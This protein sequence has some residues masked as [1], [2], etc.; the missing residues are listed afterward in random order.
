MQSKPAA[1]K[2]T[3]SNIVTFKADRDW[4]APATTTSLRAAKR[5]SQASKDGSWQLKPFVEGAGA[6]R[7]IRRCSRLRPEA[8]VTPG[9]DIAEKLS[10]RPELLVRR[11]ERRVNWKVE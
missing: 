7:G 10:A 1:I 3:K 2:Y 9:K 8:P 11:G 6:A 5:T 4:S